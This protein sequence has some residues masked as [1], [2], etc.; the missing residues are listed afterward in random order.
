[1]RRGAPL[2]ICAAVALF[3][4]AT[5]VPRCYGDFVFQAGNNPQPNEFNI[6]FGAKESG[7]PIVG[8]VDHLGIDATFSSTT[9]TTLVQNAQGQAAISSG[10]TDGSINNITLTVG[11]A[12]SPWEDLIVNLQGGSG[13]AVITVNGL[14]ANGAP[15][16]EDFNFAL[17]NGQNF[18]TLLATNGESIT[19]VTVNAPGGFDVFKQPRVSSRSFVIPEPTSMLL[20][21]IGVVGFGGASWLR[22]RKLAVI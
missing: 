9:E 10:D 19:S 15:E 5:A 2:S 12:F 14:D 11:S 20:C 18:F 8:E 21:G 1:M 22:R 6:L 13:T 4:G 7:N 3:L 16:S 17:G